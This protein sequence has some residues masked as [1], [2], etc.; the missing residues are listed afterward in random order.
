MEYPK[1]GVSPNDTSRPVCQ[2]R[3]RSNGSLLGLLQLSFPQVNEVLQV[4]ERVGP[5]SNIEV[6]ASIT[7][8]P[9]ATNTPLRTKRRT[10]RQTKSKQTERS[11][12]QDSG[13]WQGSTKTPSLQG[14]IKAAPTQ[15]MWGVQPS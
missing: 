1:S 12:K 10:R 15:D 11:C 7:L 9:D 14:K 5:P 4:E 13:R 6:S 8:T 3:A 2:S